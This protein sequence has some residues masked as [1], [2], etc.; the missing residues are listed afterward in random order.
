[1]VTEVSGQ[2]IGVQTTNNSYEKNELQITVC[3]VLPE[4]LWPAEACKA[5]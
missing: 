5:R 4:A 3:A 1:M 2:P